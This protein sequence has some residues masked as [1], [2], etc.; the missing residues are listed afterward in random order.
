MYD[1]FWYL[2]IL[3]NGICLNM[4]YAEFSWIHFLSVQYNVDSNLHQRMDYCRL[5]K[6]L[7]TRIFLFYNHKISDFRFQD[8]SQSNRRGLYFSSSVKVG[9]GR[10]FCLQ[11]SQNKAWKQ[12]SSRQ[13]APRPLHWRKFGEIGLGAC[14]RSTYLHS[15]FRADERGYGHGYGHESVQPGLP[16]QL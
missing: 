3:T 6:N 8:I 11:T 4:F 12:P 2:T 14:P 7:E 13:Q 5:Q 9:F 10:L 1:F 15:F 16:W